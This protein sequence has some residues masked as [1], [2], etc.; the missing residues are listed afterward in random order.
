[1]VTSIRA[2]F[3]QMVVWSQTEMSIRAYLSLHV[4]CVRT[5]LRVCT[6]SCPMMASV[7]ACS[8]LGAYCGGTYQCVFVRVHLH[9]HVRLHARA[10]VYVRACVRSCV[11][12]S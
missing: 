12:T 1:M 10:C 6:Q 9:V 4:W 2:C 8:S 5:H 11:R 7:L 3:S